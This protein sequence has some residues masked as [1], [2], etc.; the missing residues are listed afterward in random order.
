MSGML[1]WRENQVGTFLV[2]TSPQL[3]EAHCILPHC[4]PMVTDGLL[5]QF[6]TLVMLTYELYKEKNHK[7]RFTHHWKEATSRL[8]HC[9]CLMVQ[10]N[11]IEHLRLQENVKHRIAIHFFKN[12][13][14]ADTLNIACMDTQTCMHCFFMTIFHAFSRHFILYLIENST[15]VRYPMLTWGKNWLRRSLL[16]AFLIIPAPST[17]WPF[18]QTDRQAHPGQ[19]KRKKT[20]TFPTALI[21]KIYLLWFMKI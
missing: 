7:N 20:T 12:D 13:R 4:F 11:C 8:Q 19:F 16:W 5:L 17:W 14:A 10:D 1:K 6:K 9:H 3:S 2:T 18:I 21:A 15:L